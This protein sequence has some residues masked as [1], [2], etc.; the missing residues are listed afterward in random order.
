MGIHLDSRR[1]L[2]ARRGRPMLLRRQATPGVFTDVIVQGTDRA[3]K[4]EQEPGDIR[5]GDRMVS[6]LADEIAA[7]GW[8][9]PP[10]ARDRIDIDGRSNG[11]EGAF[12]IYEGAVCIG[13]DF[14]IKGAQ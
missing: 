11:I 10:R 6:I 3:Y 4:P 8:P 13:Y 5:Q 2:L 9:G 7:A 1:R 14:H 12:A